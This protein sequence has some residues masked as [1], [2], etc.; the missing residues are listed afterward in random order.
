MKVKT[1][2][3]K[4]YE[5]EQKKADQTFLRQPY[6]K[7]WHHYSWKKVG[8]EIR[9]VAAG[10]KAE[11]FP[12]GSKIGLISKNCAHWIMAD[13]AIMMA[14]YVSVPIYPT[15]SADTINYILTHSEAVACFVGK[16]DEW[17][18][19][20]SGVPDGV[21]CYSFPFW[22]EPGYESWD[23]VIA[24][25]EPLQGQPNRDLE[26]LITIIYT[27]GT[28]GVPKGVVHNFLA[29]SFAATY[30]LQEMKDLSDN[31]RFFSYLPL[32]HVA[33]RMLVEMGGIYTGG[34]ISFAE[35]LEDFVENLKDTKPTVF[36][37]VPRI[38]TKFQQ[39]ILEKMPQKKL[40]ILL[41]IPILNGIIKN[42]IKEGLGLQNTKYALTGAA[43]LPL[44]TMNWFESIGIPICEAYAMTENCAYSHITRKENRR[45]GY[46]GQVM[47]HTEVRITDAGEILVKNPCVMIEY[48]KEPEKTKETITE[49]GFLCTGDQGEV[50]GQTFLKITGRVKDLFKTDKGKY[51]A[52][53]PIEMALSKNTLIDQIC[54]VGTNLPQPIGLV[55]LSPE[56]TGDTPKEK[57]SASLEAT[58]KEVN[59][60]LDKHE[61]VKKL[62]IV[63]DMWTIEN[64]LIT[65]T[66]KIK[67]NE[68]EKKYTAHYT[69]WYGHKGAVV[70]E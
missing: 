36:L 10:L 29:F 44:S 70:W 62:V 8:D 43:P 45:P 60:T 68:V 12:E 54:L 66:M 63:K 42:K 20:R 38:W 16:M 4:F 59:A 7:Q 28:T 2:L 26:D 18:T 32:S 27:S 51:V 57:I 48:Y 47:P 37:A 56:E 31:E 65:P 23:E 13:L 52:P 34:M 17:E 64:N 49:D 25:H 40:D 30:A 21:K 53:A 5:F 15:V 67:R 35:S 11:G 22:T 1:P 24:K 39:K 14:G 58:L 50:D 33:E 9:R 19:Q 3:E 41:K 61:V 46:V 69:Q 55:V 6:N